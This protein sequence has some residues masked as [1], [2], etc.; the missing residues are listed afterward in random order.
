[1]GTLKTSF[2]KQNETIVNTL[3]CKILSIQ[4][5]KTSSNFKVFKMA[6]HIKHTVLHISF[7]DMDDNFND[8]TKEFFT[9]FGITGK[10]K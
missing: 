4:F 2:K 1:V 10:K 8:E 3:N 9:E 6:P 5:S 7:N